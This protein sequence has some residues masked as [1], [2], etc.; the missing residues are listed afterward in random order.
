MTTFAQ[1]VQAAQNKGLNYEF[2]SLAL[3]RW[4]SDNF[5]SYQKTKFMFE[6]KGNYFWFWGYSEENNEIVF[7][8]EKYFPATGTFYKTFN[9]EREA[10]KILGLK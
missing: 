4:G 10:L 9:K 2:Y 6:Y 5:D 3:D 1:L 8:Q 7:F